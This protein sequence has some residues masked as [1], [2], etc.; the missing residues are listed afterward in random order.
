MHDYECPECGFASSG[1]STKKARD[2]R[3]K[4]HKAEHETGEPMPELI[5]FEEGHAHVSVTFALGATPCF[6]ALPLA[7]LRDD[8]VPLEEVCGGSDVS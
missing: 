7:L 5:E 4:Q 3:A 2:E 8:V 1:W 6:L